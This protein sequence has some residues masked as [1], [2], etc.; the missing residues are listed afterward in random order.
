MK[1]K[2][3]LII[4]LLP[5]LSNAQYQRLFGSTGNDIAGEMI[6]TND[7]GYAIVGDTYSFGLTKSD[8]MVTKLNASGNVQWVKT[9]G[10][11]DYDHGYDIIQ[12]TDGGYAVCGVAGG[13]TNQATLIKLNASGIVQWSKYFS[14]NTRQS[15]SSLVQT[16]DGGY[17]LAGQASTN[18]N[19]SWG[20]LVK[21]D[22]LGTLQW[23]KLIFP[24]DFYPELK[25]I[26]TTKDGGYA[27]VA[28]YPNPAYY[29]MYFIKL[30]STGTFQWARSIG[31]SSTDAPAFVRQTSD[32][33]Y[34][35]GGIAFSYQTPLNQDAFVVK[36]DNSGNRLWSRTY[37]SVSKNESASDI[38]ELPDGG[39]A[40]LGISDSSFNSVY[41]PLLLRL[42]KNGSLMSSKVINVTDNCYTTS[43][44]SV[45][46]G[47]FAIVGTIGSLFNNSQEMFFTRFDKNGN[48]CGGF[49]KV[50]YSKDTGTLVSLTI[51]VIN[52]NTIA[53]PGVEVSVDRTL[54][55]T[56]ICQSDIN[57]VVNNNQTQSIRI[58]PNPAKDFIHIETNAVAEKIISA[59]VID[60]NGNMMMQ[61]KNL[62][63]NQINISRLKPGAYTL[64]VHTAAKEYRVMFMKEE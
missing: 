43:V 5:F 30:S 54:T 13:N 23:S 7:G 1:Q 47:G 10:I 24:R 36:M 32:D 2:L 53:A 8:V 4:I 64:I 28:I 57:A 60:L 33:G 50:N 21:T 46:A 59:N 42:N 26:I 62:S 40:V 11:S 39:F 20:Y 12:T 35:F 51:P 52:A 3:L 49:S 41:S 14:A 48:T 45:N 44:T 17:A 16:P 15:F 27:V 38:Q 37:G 56:G 61:L 18:N 25:D 58:Y 31:G 6:H 9:F 34:I 55:A 19:G 63:S 22:S 29:D